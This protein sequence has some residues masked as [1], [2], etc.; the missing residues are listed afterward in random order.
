MPAIVR[1]LV[2]S[3]VIALGA[4]AMAQDVSLRLG[5]V[6]APA[7]TTHVMLEKVAEM[8]AE[9]TDGAVEIQVYPQSQL[10]S[11]R[12][13][14]EAVQFGALDATA[15]PV[16]F[17][18]GFNP[19]GS[20]MD[21]PFL[22]PADPEKAQAIREGGFS[23][24]FC[25]SFN[26]R[27]VTCVS[28][29]PNGVKQFTSNKPIDTPEAFEGQ[30][31]RVMESAVLVDSMAAIGVTGVPLPFGELYTSL[32]TG[33]VDGEENPLDT[34]FNMKFF[35]VQDYLALSNHGAIENV[36]LFN[37]AVWDG[38]D[39]AHREAISTSLSEIIPEMIAHKAAAGEKSLEA[40]RAANV[41][42]IEPTP[43]QLAALRDKMFPAARDAFL[44][45]AGD[46]GA[47]LF[48]AYQAAYDDVM[49]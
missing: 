33:V 17:M 16:A 46:E 14:T 27:G 8:V 20:I 35:E 2:I 39:P 31:F 10:G 45:R 32:Q 22:Y 6:E 19:V 36:V 26:S 21:I 42:V 3:A 13:M 24:A 41:T 23:A 47:A 40:I 37:P 38:L 49:K 48:E 7:S 25:E 18:G 12:E 43:E 1:P 11:Q 30:S 9:K 44:E 28:H 34:I 4:P 5:H 29:Y 15:G